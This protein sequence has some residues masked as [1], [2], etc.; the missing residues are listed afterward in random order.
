[1][2]KQIPNLITSLNL[3]CG[4]V[5]ALCIVFG[6]PLAAAVFAFSGIFFDFFDG[7]AARALNAQSEI[8]L[9]MDSLADMITSGLV[10]G[11][12]MM[13]LLSMAV[14]G[15]DLSVWFASLLGESWNL[16]ANRWL[17]LVGLLIVVG[18]A[19]R[20]AKFNVD[21]RQTDYFIGLP[22]P[23][24]SLFMLSLPLIML[25]DGTPWVKD[26]LSTPWVLIV[27]TVVFSLLLNA[28]IKLF[29]LKFKSWRFKA[30]RVAYVFIVFSAVMILLY[31]FLAIPVIIIAYIIVSVL[32]SLLSKN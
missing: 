15:D 21:T 10:P 26:L 7:L 8:G 3:L 23:A 14:I 6:E 16:S 31:K 24:N 4:C 9:Q 29:S 20:L 19:Y 27:I 13:H 25:Y 32:Q 11:L 17:P 28:N 2:V 5:A 18:S 30:N 12:V 22:T 1:M